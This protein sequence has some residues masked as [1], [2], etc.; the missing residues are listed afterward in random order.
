M[1]WRIK[2]MATGLHNRGKN[3]FD[4]L[5]LSYIIKTFVIDFYDLTNFYKI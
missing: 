3:D 1:K 4:K 5:I 2:N